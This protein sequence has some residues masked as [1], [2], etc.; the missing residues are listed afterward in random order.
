VREDVLRATLDLLREEGLDA[1][2][3]P[4]V[5]ARAAV[6][7]TSVY[8]RWGD[9]SGLIRDALLEAVADSELVGAAGAAAPGPESAGDLRGD[10]LGLVHGV[11]ALRGTAVGA[12]LLKVLRCEDPVLTDVHRAY[13]KGRSDQCAAIVERAVRRGE[14][15]PG[16]DPRLVLELLVGP[17]FGPGV[18]DGG[19][20]DDAGESARVEPEALVDAVLDGIRRR[21]PGGARAAAAA[22]LAGA[23]ATGAPAPDGDRPRGRAQRRD[24]VYAAAVALFVERGFDST[25]MEDIAERAAVAR[26][27][28]FNHF[29]RKTAFL[30]EWSARRRRRAEDAVRA[31]R[32][33]DRPIREILPRYMVELAGLNVDGRV[34]TVALF[35]AAARATDLLGN[36]ALAGELAV[37]FRRGRE[38][39]ELARSVDP[40]L[41]GML[42]ATGYFATLTRWIAAEPAPFDLAARLQE[43]VSLVLDDV[44]PVDR[45]A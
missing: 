42:L 5:A 11:V 4:G 7:H 15:A 28:V 1:V 17:L 21:G 2:T 10:L 27:T 22:P 35:S 14:A 44:S 33:E 36:Q 41:A 30:A 40:E 45:G 26:A 12:V 3:I 19:A 6:H 38:R 24:A 37:I 25:T 43:L 32:L 23:P 8:R 29:P 20:A 39:G 16:T 31:D 13:W 9:R 34:E 18:V